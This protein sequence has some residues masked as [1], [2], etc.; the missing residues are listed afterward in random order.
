MSEQQDLEGLTALVTGAT[1]GIGRATAEELARHG[2]DVVGDSAGDRVDRRV[3]DHV[4]V[5]PAVLVEV[6]VEHPRLQ[7]LPELHLHTHA[8]ATPTA[9]RSNRRNERIRPKSIPGWFGMVQPA[10]ESRAASMTA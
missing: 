1:S 9:V 7:R 3:D 5:H 6:G 8:T 10:S 2:A 4:R